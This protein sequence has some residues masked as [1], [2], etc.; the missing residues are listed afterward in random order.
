MKLG[1]LS[2]LFNHKCIRQSILHAVKDQQISLM[3]EDEIQDLQRE[4]AHKLFSLVEIFEDDYLTEAKL[5]Q[6]LLDL[7]TS[8]LIP[9]L[10]TTDSALSTYLLVLNSMKY[11]LPN[12]LVIEQP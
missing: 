3:S 7:G 9:C 10:M 5:Y 8:K 1:T 6:A 11:A 12:A 2:R 4:G